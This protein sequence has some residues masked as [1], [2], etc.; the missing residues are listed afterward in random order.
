MNIIGPFETK[1]RIGL[2]GF[3]SENLYLISLDF[4]STI[5]YSISVQLPFFGQYFDKLKNQPLDGLTQKYSTEKV[6]YTDLVEVSVKKS[7]WKNYV[8]VRFENKTVK[9]NIL[10]PNHTDNYEKLIS[11]ITAN[12]TEK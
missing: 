5:K 8:I 10:E 6:K 3:D 4:C 12:A 1:T 7:N 11:K 9:W 2:I